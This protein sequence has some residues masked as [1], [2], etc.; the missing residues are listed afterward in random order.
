MRSI[1]IDEMR[2]RVPG[3]SAAD[4]QRLGESVAQRLAANPGA[5]RGRSIPSIDLR[6]HA[7]ASDSVEQL[8]DT[9]AARIRMKP[10]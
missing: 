9:I 2:L 8:A 10:D 3:L 6:L 4:A 1:R 5:L 7:A